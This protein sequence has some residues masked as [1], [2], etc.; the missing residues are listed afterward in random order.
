MK[1][2]RKS[3]AS[4]AAAHDSDD[5]HAEF[6]VHIPEDIDTDSLS[7]ILPDI[8]FSSPSPEAIAN[9]YRILLNQALEGRS[10]TQELDE[11]R[12]EIEKKEVELDQAL[13]DKESVAKDCEAQV[14]SIQRDLAQVKQGR[15][16]LGI[17]CC[18]AIIFLC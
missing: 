10:I 18:L 12:A 1:T 7:D 5:A 16:Q 13:Q 17:I 9:V 6:F 11:A 3:K 14:E 4:L 2:R 8:D 15:D